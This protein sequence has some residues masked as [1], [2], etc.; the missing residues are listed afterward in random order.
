MTKPTLQIFPANTE[1]CEDD[2]DDDA[3]MIGIRID[4]DLGPPNYHVYM[5]CT[6][7]SIQAIDSLKAI[8]PVQVD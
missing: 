6:E 7:H 2:C 4:W 3:T 1:C 5:F 8:E